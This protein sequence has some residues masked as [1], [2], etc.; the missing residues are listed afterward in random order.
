MFAKKSSA[1]TIRRGS[2]ETPAPNKGKVGRIHDSAM[3]AF[4]L[5]FF[6]RFNPPYTVVAKIALGGKGVRY[7][8][9]A[10]MPR[11]FFLQTPESILDRAAD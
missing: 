2:F 7:S 5:L 4:A 3:D 10:S 8:C 6:A 11:Y 9:V 1:A